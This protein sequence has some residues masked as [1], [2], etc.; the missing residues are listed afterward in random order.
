MGEGARAAGAPPPEEAVDHW[1]GDDKA[2]RV[3]VRQVLESHAHHPVALERRAAA[4]ALHTAQR[5]AVR[6]GGVKSLGSRL[7]P[8]LL[9]CVCW[10]PGT[11][12][13]FS[14]V[15]PQSRAAPG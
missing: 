4:V 11:P 1:R 7:A 8:Q 13:S 15:D 3:G 10:R 14:K 6:G 5:S 9:A 12:G 2:D